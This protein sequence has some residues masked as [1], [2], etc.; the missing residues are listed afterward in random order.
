MSSFVAQK[1]GKFRGLSPEF[2][3]LV[4]RGNKLPFQLTF[5]FHNSAIVS[6]GFAD[7]GATAFASGKPIYSETAAP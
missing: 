4:C 3:T 7:L 6:P 5:P 2:I 1:S